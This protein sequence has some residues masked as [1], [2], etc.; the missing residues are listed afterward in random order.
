MTAT[1]A[2]RPPKLR[3]VV[4]WFDVRRRHPGAWAF[5]L[6]RLTGIVLALYLFLHLAVLSLLGRGPQ[7]WDDF[8]ALVHSPIAL[9]LEATL[10]AMLLVHAL[11]GLRVVLVGLAVGAKIQ[12]ALFGALMAVAAAAA[13][14]STILI[15]RS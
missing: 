7:A 1:G 11:N 10:V 14:V 12:K 9:A 8:L 5:A 4:H 6:N 15:F 13:A 3:R 2:V